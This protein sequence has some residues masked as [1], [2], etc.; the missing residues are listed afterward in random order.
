MREVEKIEGGFNKAVMKEL[1]P[2]KSTGFSE[3]LLYSGPYGALKA[4]QA[5]APRRQ[6]HP[7]EEER[8]G[9]SCQSL[10][11]FHFQDTR[12]RRRA[13]SERLF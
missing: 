10:C 4:R 8:A 6:R 13:L 12:Q 1:L 9:R 2:A 11:W 3:C 7:G 5:K